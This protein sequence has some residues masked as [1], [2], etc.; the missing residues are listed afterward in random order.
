MKASAV[1]ALPREVTG[2][3]CPRVLATNETGIN[4]S[5]RVMV[6]RRASSG[7]LQAKGVERMPLRLG[8]A[9]TD[10]SSKIIGFPSPGTNGNRAL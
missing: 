8:E 2:K 6:W 7:S 9:R 4:I 1:G 3:L 5:P 10:C